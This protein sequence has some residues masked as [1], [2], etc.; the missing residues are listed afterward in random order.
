L[1]LFGSVDILYAGESSAR[2]VAPEL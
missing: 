2:F 1:I